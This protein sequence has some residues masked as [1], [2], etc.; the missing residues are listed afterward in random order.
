MSQIPFDKVRNHKK[1]Q[2]QQG[3]KHKKNKKTLFVA[4]G[5]A[6]YYPRLDKGSMGQDAHVIQQDWGISNGRQQPKILETRCKTENEKSVKN[7]NVKMT[8]PEKAPRTDSS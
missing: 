7:K 3:G 1:T 2:T 5:L 8:P 4:C 6:C